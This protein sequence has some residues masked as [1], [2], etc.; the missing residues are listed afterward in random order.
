MGSAD[1][2]SISTNQVEG[3]DEDEKEYKRRKKKRD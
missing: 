2:P 3:G 1:G